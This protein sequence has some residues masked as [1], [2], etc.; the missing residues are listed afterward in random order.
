MAAPTPIKPEGDAD[1]RR[2]T[3]AA[4][5]R[6]H[7]GYPTRIDAAMLDRRMSRKEQTA[8]LERLREEQK[9]LGIAIQFLDVDDGEAK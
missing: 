2:N 3:V 4:L 5:Q 1:L 7:S 6:I 8:E 9:A